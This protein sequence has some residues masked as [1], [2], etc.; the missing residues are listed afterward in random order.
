MN[1]VI[2]I[3]P[4]ALTPELLSIIKDNARAHQG[5]KDTME[6]I[7]SKFNSRS[8]P[9]GIMRGNNYTQQDNYNRMDGAPFTVGNWYPVGIQCVNR[10]SYSHKPFGQYVL[11]FDPEIGEFIWYDLMEWRDK[12]RFYSQN[13]S[14]YGGK[15]GKSI[16]LLKTLIPMGMELEVT[17]R[18]SSH[19]QCEECRDYD[20]DNDTSLQSFCEEDDYCYDYRHSEQLSEGFKF[21]TASFRFLVELNSSFG[22]VG[23]RSKPVWIVKDDSSVD[24]EF[25]SAPMT[26]RA[27][28]AGFEINTNLFNSFE[29]Y[30]KFAKG[31]HGPCGGHIHIDKALMESFSY[32]AFL[33]MHYENPELI[34]DIAQR[35]INEDSRWCYLQKPDS[36]AKVAKTKR[37]M[38]NRGALNQTEYS[39]ELRYFRS[40]LKVDRL[41]KNVEWIQSLYHFSSQ[42]TFQDMSRDNDHRL[43]FYILFLKANRDKYPEIFKYLKSKGYLSDKGDTYLDIVDHGG[44]I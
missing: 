14:Y 2:K 18:N 12:E 39:L 22:A 16:D 28:R 21:D 4:T 8:F 11:D 15:Y 20:Y 19:R 1:K 41:I 35:N 43:K 27:Y 37:G 23:T 24:L 31:Y 25:V 17:A 33:A 6:N 5:L 13:Y 38:A 40:N 30:S 32:Y 34:A 44:D 26:L 9:N 3:E 29:F 36:L 10:H 42:L 7:R